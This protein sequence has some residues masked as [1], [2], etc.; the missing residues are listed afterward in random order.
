[1][2]AA[3]PPLGRDHI[4]EL[5]GFRG[6][7]V[8]GVFWTHLPDGALGS[9]MAAWKH[10]YIPGEFA[11]DLFFV[12]SGFLI[13]RILIAERER[14][15]PLRYFLFRRVLRIFPV[16][17]IT[18]FVLWP[19]LLVEELWTCL[20]YTSNFGFLFIDRQG[21]LEQTW[22]LSVEEQFYLVWPPII[23]FFGLAFARKVIW[24]AFFPISV[25]TVVLAYSYGP[26][27]TDAGM[28]R[29]FVFRSSTSRFLSLGIGA[30]VA[31]NE[32]RIRESKP[33]SLALIAGGLFVGWLFTLGAVHDLGIEP[34][35][36]RVPSLSKDYF[37][38]VVHGLQVFSLPGFSLACLIAAITW[39]GTFAPQ[40]VFFRL[41]PLRWIGRISYGIY[42]FHLG[43]LQAPG[44]LGINRYEPSL[45]YVAGTVVLT[46]LL[47]T[48]SFWLL[49][50]PLLEFGKRY[51]HRPQG[52]KPPRVPLS[53]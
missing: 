29:L 6:L 49:E 40:A 46:M 2:A 24:Y 51:R 43:I 3:R 39:T 19:R 28:M 53:P 18:I 11:L 50:R 47:A 17:F 1:M 23:A 5:D 30:L 10:K 31:F 37:N 32:R 42:I 38:N 21:P 9:Q 25:L 22:S 41:P 8:F 44:V 33:I 4:P 48:A 34:Y 16:Y 27:D 35:L 52:S 13:T 45:A 14:G 7:G 15:V 26:W 36:R 20:T 12:M